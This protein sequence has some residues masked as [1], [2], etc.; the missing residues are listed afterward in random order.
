MCNCEKL[1]EMG[2]WVDRDNCPF[3]ASCEAEKG[4][5]KKL[6]KD[7]LPTVFLDSQR[8][9]RFGNKPKQLRGL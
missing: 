4:L 5:L 6:P 7:S 3:R 2:F 9:E 8:D 1:I